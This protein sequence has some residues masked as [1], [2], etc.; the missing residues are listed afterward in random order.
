MEIQTLLMIIEEIVIDGSV[1]RKW[2]SI[3]DGERE[4][5]IN[6]WPPLKKITTKKR[7]QEKMLATRFFDVGD[8]KHSNF[9]LVT[10]KSIPF[11]IGVRA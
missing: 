11:T 1:I 4:H 9:R 2:V 3:E 10:L 7:K 8:D 6:L 5:W